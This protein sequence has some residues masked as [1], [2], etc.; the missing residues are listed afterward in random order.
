LAFALSGL[1]QIAFQ[2]SRLVGARVLLNFLLGRYHR[3]VRE[4]RIFM[5]LDLARST[6]LAEAM[7]ELQVTALL[8]RFFQDIDQPIAEYGGEVHSYIGD[9]V[10]I[11]WSLERGLAEARC[12]R[13]WFAIQERIAALAPDYLRDFG[14]V[15]EFRAGLHAGPIVVSEVGNTKRQIAYFGDTVNV[16]ARLQ[17]QAKFAGRAF[18]ASAELLRWVAL[19]QGVAAESLGPVRLAGRHQSLEVVALSR[20]DPR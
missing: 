3:P 13:C 8:S 6:E 14:L 12:I 18:L 15:P 7:G 5:F 10:V 11:T 9:Q 17:H 16:A 19:P 1:V 2:V 20:E 4:E